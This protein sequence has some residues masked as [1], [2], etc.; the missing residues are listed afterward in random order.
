MMKLPLS[1]PVLSLFALLLPGCED[2][3]A[4]E[5]TVSVE[6]LAALSYGPAV[7]QFDERAAVKAAVS[8]AKLDENWT[9]IR[10][11]FTPIDPGYHLYS[12]DLPMEG[13]E[14]TGRPTY[15]E[16]TEGAVQSGALLADQEPHEFTQYG[17]TLP[18]YHEGAVTLYRLVQ[19]KS[20]ATGLTAALTY[21]SCS[22]E[23]CN[24]PIEGETVSVVL[25]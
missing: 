21:M 5:P 14:E 16:I 4:A 11:V 12:K 13:I 20:G 3:P 24:L 22:T 25:P 7:E 23:L 1:I 9:V 18:V 15:L 8:A 6:Q 10:G 17:V 19:P 2:P